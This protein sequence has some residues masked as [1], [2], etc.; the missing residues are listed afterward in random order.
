MLS[1]LNSSG[2]VGRKIGP[3]V[4]CSSDG[5][6]VTQN[7]YVQLGGEPGPLNPS[8]E[9]VVPNGGF[10]IR[11]SVNSNEALLVISNPASSCAN[12]R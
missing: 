9:T 6:S 11:C 10:G 5:V 12:E 4:L 1:F 3:K 8:N 2:V 7:S